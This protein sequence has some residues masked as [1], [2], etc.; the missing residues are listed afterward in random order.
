MARRHRL[1]IFQS[2]VGAITVD[3]MD[4]PALRRFTMSRFPDEDVF[5]AIRPLVAPVGIADVDVAAVTGLATFP[6]RIVLP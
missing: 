5:G 4:M 3:V 1:K 6:R 2:V